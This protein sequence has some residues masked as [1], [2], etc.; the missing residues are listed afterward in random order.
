[1]QSDHR[2]TERVLDIL[3]LLAFRDASD[4]LT[5]TEISNSLQSPKS[6]ISPI[7]HT[8]AKKSTCHTSRDPLLIRW[9]SALWKS[10]TPI[11]GRSPF[12]NVR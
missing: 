4:G 10:E 12:L 3:E 8:M 11:C 6:S 9:E 1:M 5:L 7:L 2:S